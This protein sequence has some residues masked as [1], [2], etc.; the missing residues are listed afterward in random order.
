MMR[1]RDA[2]I[3]NVTSRARKTSHK[4]GIEMPTDKYHFKRLDAKN[5]NTF[6]IDAIKK[7]IHD[8]GIAFE[9]L[10]DN[11]S[12]PMRHRKITAHLVFDM[13]MGFTRK[14][15]WVLDEYKA[16]SPAGS[17]HAGVVSR[18]SVRIAFNYAALN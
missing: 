4:Y 9:I 12:M 8:V 17:T 10:E 11:A 5:G 2:T 18:E 16:P 14:A 13:K 7:E 1:K 3:V 15:R 6:W